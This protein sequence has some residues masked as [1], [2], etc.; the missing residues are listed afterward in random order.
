FDLLKYAFPYFWGT[1]GLIYDNTKEG[2]LEQ[3]ETEG[4]GILTDQS[5]TKMI[6]ES[7]R[8]VFMAALFAQDPVKSLN[9]ATEQDIKDAKDWLLSTKGPNTVIE[10]AEIL[11]KAIGGNVPYDIAMV[12]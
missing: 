7:P 3:L 8:D 4:W 1:I 6:Y 12:Y 11:E 9:T 2:L 10:S 5:L